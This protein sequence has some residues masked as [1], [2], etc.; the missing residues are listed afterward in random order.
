M[1][2]FNYKGEAIPLERQIPAKP[3]P[4]AKAKTGDKTTEG[5]WLVTGWT[6]TQVLDAG[7]RL[8][9]LGAKD[10]VI[11]IELRNEKRHKVRAKPYELHQAA[12]ECARLAEKAG[13]LGVTVTERRKRV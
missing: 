11:L 5:G 3:A 6:P 9:D 13:W 12:L 7:M 4:R 2:L 10:S 1:T 8:K